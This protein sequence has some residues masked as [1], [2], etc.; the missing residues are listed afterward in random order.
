MV[1]KTNSFYKEAI[2][3]I[4]SKHKDAIVYFIPYPKYEIFVTFRLPK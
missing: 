1:P 3:R 2:L 4:K